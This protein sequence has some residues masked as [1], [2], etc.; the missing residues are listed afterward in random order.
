MLLLALLLLLALAGGM[1]ALNKALAEP[2]LRMEEAGS[3]DAPDELG[4]SDENSDPLLPPCMML[5]AEVSGVLNSSWM[6]FICI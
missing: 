4:N 6:V 1:S 3:D 2:P 5:R